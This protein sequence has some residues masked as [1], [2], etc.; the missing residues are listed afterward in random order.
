MP[1]GHVV[2]RM[3][4]QLNAAFAGRPVQVSSP[5]G[6]FADAAALLDGTLFDHAEAV[7]KH[8]F[9]AFEADQWVHVHLGLIGKLRWGADADARGEVRMRVSDGTHTLELLAPQWCRLVTGDEVAAVVADSGPDPLRPDAD[10]LRG[11]DRLHR[12]RRSVAALLM[13]QRVSA[14]V[15]NIFRA[16]TL[17]RQRIDPFIPGTSLRRASWEALW[18]DLTLLM[19]LAVERGR[20]DTVLP[21]HEPDAMGRDPRVDKHGGEVYVYRRAGEPCLVCGSRVRTELHAGRNLFWCGR[22]QRRH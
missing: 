11:W 3:A 22:C 7:G 14:G 20:I 18:A 8:L 6:R 5:Q 21:E 4:H 1:E 12:S 19:P 13:D 15:G 17:F 9:L 2:H 16:E 10:P